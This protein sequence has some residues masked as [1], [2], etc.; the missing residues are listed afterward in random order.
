[1][2]ISTIN[3][4][5]Y[6]NILIPF[7]GFWN[8]KRN[9]SPVKHNVEADEFIKQESSKPVKNNDIELN[10]G[11]TILSLKLADVLHTL[12]D[13]EIVA[14]G[15][16]ESIF[17]KNFVERT[18]TDEKSFIP[19]PKKIKQIY[20]INDTN[21][22]SPLLIA[23]KSNDEFYVYGE[24]KN[25]S[26]CDKYSS[27]SHEPV[28]W[29]EVIEKRNGRK[30]KLIDISTE[31]N[32]LLYDAKFPVE[33]F[34]QDDFYSLRN[35]L[36][37]NDD[38]NKNIKDNKHLQAVKNSSL[39]SCASSIPSKTFDDI[40]G[41]DDT[42]K[43]VKRKILYPLLYPGAF[44][45]IMNRGT[46]FYGEPG[47]GK[48]LL[49]LAVIGEAKKRTGQNIHFI[50]VNSK[51]LERSNFGESEALWRN[52]F[53]ELE[54]NQP[55]LL[56]IDEI[57]AILAKRQEGSNYVP[58][59]SIV[60][61]FLTLLDNLEKNKIHTVIIGTT[62]RPEM[63]DPAITRNGRLGN[64]IEI[65]KPDEKGCLDIL[66][67]Y[68]KDKNISEDFDREKFSKKLFDLSSTGADIA[69]MVVNATDSMYE[70]CGIYNKMEDG[71]YSDKD[72]SNLIYTK[73]DFENALANK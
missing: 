68:L 41:M 51:D 38:G 42:I 63:I 26:R 49:A 18:L 53:K 3:S 54:E 48:T 59:N 73:E 35:G 8:A 70:R 39:N 58:N 6:N 19:H 1:M 43:L 5:S 24:G 33:S 64:L 46:I 71:T 57:D 11:D 56:F 69:A 16:Y 50:K 7:K 22:H 34:F 31:S 4:L 28:R 36:I 45:G 21:C 23:R 20:V 30:I 15:D 44:P 62:N 13:E 61:Q 47:T 60:S 25:L 37:L 10:A 14:V 29:D 2:R 55:S 17:F 12:S 72:L 52:V 40:A 67:F 66:N 65:K 32:N 9:I 27:Y